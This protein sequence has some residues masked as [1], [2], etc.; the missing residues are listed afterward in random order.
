MKNDVPGQGE[1]FR[2][3]EEGIRDADRPASRNER[4]VDLRPVP[5][6]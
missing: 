6:S 5:R 4:K 1:T 3:L 2:K